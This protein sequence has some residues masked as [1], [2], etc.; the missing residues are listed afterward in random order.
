[1]PHTRSVS[2]SLCLEQPRPAS[3]EPGISIVQSSC[4]G[5]WSLVFGLWSL[6]SGSTHNVTPPP[7]RLWNL[8]ND[9]SIR[10]ERFQLAQLSPAGPTG[11]ALA[12]ACHLP[13]D[14]LSTAT[15]P[16]RVLLCSTGQESEHTS[17]AEPHWEHFSVTCNP[18]CL[19]LQAIC[20]R[21]DFTFHFSAR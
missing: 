5:L 10:T 7:P 18:A 16:D 14:H 11:Q 4:A 13:F 20:F 12:W 9:S 17:R 3:L 2:C 15:I 19:N 1:M 6:V 8:S 21:E